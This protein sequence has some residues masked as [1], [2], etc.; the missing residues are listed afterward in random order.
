MTAWSS[1]ARQAGRGS[2]DRRA[3]SGTCLHGDPL[4]SG[5]LRDRRGARAVRHGDFERKSLRAD[6][7]A[8][9]HRA[10]QQGTASAAGQPLCGLVHAPHPSSSALLAYGFSGDPER[11]LA[12]LVVATPCPLILATPVAIIGGI[13]R[14]ARSGNHRATRRRTR[15]PVHRGHRAFRQDR[16]SHRGT[17]R[18]GSGPRSPALLRKRKFFDWPVVGP[19]SGHLLA[20]TLVAEAHGRGIV[21]PTV[22]EVLETAGRGVTGLIEGRRVTVGAFS[23]IR[24]QS[25]VA[26][27]LVAEHEAGPALRAFVTVDG[28]PAGSISYA[29]RVRD[30]APGVIAGLRALGIDRIALLSGD[31]AENV[32]A[33]AKAVGIDEVAADLLPRKKWTTSGG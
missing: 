8:G 14:A 33:V 9:A 29:D 23:L 13:N 16:H 24:E 25:R 7:G 19:A 27:V 11:V 1:R 4:R 5:S 21:L 30:E 17:T 18:R 3:I 12:V 32:A 6:R 20:R 10:G 15:S 22:P 2:S 31:H 28:L 26:R